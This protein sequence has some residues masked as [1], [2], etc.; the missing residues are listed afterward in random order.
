MINFIVKYKF[1]I[2]LDDYYSSS[3]ETILKLSYDGFFLNVHLKGAK[4]VRARKG[5]VFAT[6]TLLYD[7]DIF[8][9]GS[10]ENINTTEKFQVQSEMI[11]AKS[12][13]SYSMFQA[14]LC[15]S[16]YTLTLRDKENVFHLL[17][18]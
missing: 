13:P 11:G 15:V 5:K 12:S 7:E 18:N 3:S 2:G 17:T 10:N 4:H 16:Y 9:M 1:Q 8:K 6:S 14:P